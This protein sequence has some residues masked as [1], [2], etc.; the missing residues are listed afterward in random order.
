MAVAS[1]L[2]VKRAMATVGLIFILVITGCAGGDSET[3]STAGEQ[4]PSDEPTPND[5][6]PPG[7]GTNDSGNQDN[8][9]ALPVATY[10]A[11][12]TSTHFSGSANCALCHNGLTNAAGDN[13]AIESDWSTSMM[14]NS[15]RD[16]FWRAKVASEMLRN[17]LYKTVLDDKCSRCHAPM[18]NVEAKYDGVSVE[19]FADGFL[20]PENSYY[21]HAMGGVSCTLCHQIE[22]NSTLGTEAG[23]SGGYRIVDLG[24]SGERKAFGQYANPTINPMLTN[25]GF[26]PTQSPHISRSKICATCHNLKTPFV[27]SSGTLV[28]TTPDTEFPEQMVYTEWENSEFATGPT[29]QSC[30]DCHM[31]KTD[32]VKIA[33]RPRLLTAR[34]DFSRHTMVGANTTMLDI[35]ASNK[36][37]LAVGGGDYDAAITRTRTM[38]ETAADM[39]VVSQSLTD[40]ELTVRLRIN[41]RSGHKL[42]TSFPSR[43][44]YIHF[45][46]RDESDNILFESGKTN[47]NGSIVGAD[48]D[49]DLTRFEPHYEEI[50][51]ENQVQIYE[52]IM[53]DTDGNVTYTLLRG[54]SY[55]KDNRI[56]PAGFDK[57]NVPDDIRVAGAAMND[58]DFNAGSDIVTYRVFVGSTNTVRLTAE[59]KYQSLAYGFIKDLFQDNNSP[60]IAKFETLYNN[61]A[62]RSETITAVNGTSP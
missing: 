47:L 9:T 35:L 49:T 16:P 12:F 52:P 36:E 40:S 1:E 31:P 25:S 44:A 8:A 46:V 22:D 39:E 14:A 33:N 15:T 50:T 20:N 13:V 6:L 37:E 27:D 30:Q 26:R 48:G 57:N 7:D 42:P 10:D 60:E 23:F 34:N 59:L 58:S 56:P 29:A 11:N 41:N 38:L 4:A 17:P 61:A 55:L 45:V 2:H 62:I 19:L 28:S 51:Q 54:A 21:N 53:G 3:D 18:A 32:G 43:R 5:P 24:V